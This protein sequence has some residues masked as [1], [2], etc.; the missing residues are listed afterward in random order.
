MKFRVIFLKKAHIY[1]LLL[2]LLIVVL[3]IIFITSKTSSTFNT[4]SNNKNIKADFNGD[5]KED[6]LSV[7][8][9]DDNY[10][11]EATIDNK[12]F[13]LKTDKNSPLIETYSPYWPLRVTLMDISRNKVPEIFI[14][15]S[16]NN[17]PLQRVFIFH[18]SNFDN[19]LSSSNNIL[20]F[21]DC[22]N[23][24]TPK[25]ISGKIQGD[26]ITFSN[27]IFLNYKFTNYSYDTDKTFI[28][29]DTIYTFI[30]L[31]E[32]LPQSESYKPGSIFSSNISKE[33]MSLIGNLSGENNSYVFQDALFKENKCNKNG[34][35]SE[36]CWTLNFR[37]ISN[38]DNSIIKN[39]TL[40]LVLTPDKNSKENYYF[41]IASMYK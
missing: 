7:T 24:K 17:K 36:V 2:I 35:I 6:I 33:D 4:I 25:V 15:G 9:V 22:V 34:D 13:S 21:I 5:G 27:Y 28:G 31:I 3:S 40:N 18:D 26:T 14:Q 16:K 38:A 12:T 11:M 41:K 32:G 23:N 29:K 8:R 19:I 30:K 10:L 1:L 37:G 20:G 39:Y